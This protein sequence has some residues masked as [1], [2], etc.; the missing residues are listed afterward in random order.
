MKRNPRTIWDNMKILT[1]H[2]W[3][4][5]YAFHDKKKPRRNYD[6]KEHIISKTVNAHM[7]KEV[8]SLTGM[9]IDNSLL[10]WNHFL[11]RVVVH[12]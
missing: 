6:L 8:H 11:S 7:L 3:Y 4:N 9:T 12:A 10:R 5:L 2:V 1:Y